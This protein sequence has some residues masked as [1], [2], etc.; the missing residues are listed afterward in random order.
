MVSYVKYEPAIESL[1]NKLLDLF[2]TTDTI[3]LALGRDTDAPN[4]STDDELADQTQPTGTGYTAGGDDTQNDSTRSGGTVTETAVDHTW[5]AGAADWQSFRYG[6]RQD[7]TSI[8]DRLLN[9]WDY[10]STV[11]LGNA[12]TFQ[13][14]YGASVATYA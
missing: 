13:A 3:K 10:G 7:D 6:V 4:A 1:T 12:E 9:Y 2:G 14:D 8:T 11:N 5:T